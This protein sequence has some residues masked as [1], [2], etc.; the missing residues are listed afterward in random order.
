MRGLVVGLLLPFCSTAVLAF[1]WPGWVPEVPQA[2]PPFPA[3]TLIDSYHVELKSDGTRTAT[4]RYAIHA[5]SDRG[6]RATSLVVGRTRFQNVTK[7]KAWVREPDGRTKK[8]DED[9]G[10]LWG[11]LDR[12]EMGDGTLLTLHP[13]G[14]RAGSTLAVE[15]RL[16]RTADWPQ[17]RFEFQEDDTP[18][19]SATFDVEAP[20]GWTVSAKVAHGTNPGAAQFSGRSSYA[21]HDVAP[22]V[23]RDPDTP[24]SDIDPDPPRSRGALLLDYVRTGSEPAFA[25]WS[26]VA[27]WA[28]DLFARAS[29][30]G[31]RV[32]AV[33]DTLRESADPV[34]A[35]GR[36]AR[37]VRYF[38]LELGWGGLVPR[39]P[40]QV[41]E[42]GLGDCK[43]KS[44]LMVALLRD[45]G[46]EAVPVLIRAPRFGVIDAAA[47]TP[48]FNHA[49]V[50]IPWTG[51]EAA[52]GLTLVESPGLGTLRLIDPT[53]SA[54][55]P[56]DLSPEL[57]GA[58]GLAL[59]PRTTGALRV[60]LPDAAANVSTA[61]WTLAF[62]FSCTANVRLEQR[63]T[64][65]LREVL[66]GRD[67]DLKSPDALRKEIYP[68]L[69]EVCPGMSDLSIEPPSVGPDG[70]YLY[71]AAFRCASMCYEFGALD[72]LALPPLAPDL[73]RRRAN[74]ATRSYTFRDV[75]E[76]E[77]LPDEGVTVWPDLIETRASGSVATRAKHAPGRVTLERE[78]VLDMTHAPADARA[79]LDALRRA[80]GRANR[81]EVRVLHGDQP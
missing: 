26:G 68:R 14:I 17:D 25:T 62:E 50:G 38:A 45:R 57:A 7:I 64:G 30:E 41:I 28:I 49:I 71:R 47:P 59:S 29:E 5:L 23:D 8:Y 3:V 13:P 10:T 36:Y 6:A 33:R 79:D 46:I 16:T 54:G 48:D 75:V 4:R 44:V 11:V 42:R 43:D 70:A 9:D 1:G 53:L 21:F 35:A 78:A 39:S 22:A 27:R 81:T 32:A 56:L 74:R 60:P 18:V 73:F 80:L 55:S 67:R 69:F 61:H 24:E 58:V 76:V 66:T 12:N 63:Y 52:P 77:G 40:E 20:S 2:P 19:L 31:K 72:V 37:G 15:Y 34:A 51:K 65:L